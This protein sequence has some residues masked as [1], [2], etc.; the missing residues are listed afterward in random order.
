[1][2]KT[3]LSILLLLMVSQYGFS[4]KQNNLLVTPEWLSERINDDNIVVFHVDNEKSYKEEH[5]KGARFISWKDYTYDDDSHVFDLPSDDALKTMFENKGINNGDKIVL[6]VSG[7]MIPMMSRVFLTLDYL[8]YGD[9]TYLLD[10][11]LPLWKAMGG[12]TN[13]EIP[14]VTKGTFTIK[15][16]KSLFTNVDYVRSKLN[17]PGV[18]I[19]DGRAPV[20]YQ[21]IDA[22]NG[23]KSRKG[24]VP[25]AKTIPYTSL[26]EKNIN[27]SFTFL[28][29]IELEQL[30]KNQNLEDD[31]QIIL[32]CHIG[33]QLSAVYVAA[34]MLGYKDIKVYDGS[35][36][37]W[38]PDDSL[39]IE[40]ED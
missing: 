11:G 33:M 31:K 39:P 5:I 37:E 4:Q 28:S 3:Y 13:S 19:I 8:G 12:E 32:Y 27:G 34:K 40:L 9:N 25:G 1:M 36:Y 21:G 2:K 29:Q 22:G 35:F 15:P 7:H 14:D 23:G 24:H 10:G 26:Y 18:N 6:Y 17:D 38:G 20:Y 16:N 30:F